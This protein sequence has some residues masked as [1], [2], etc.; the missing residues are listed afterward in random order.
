MFADLGDSKTGILL[1]ILMDL[2]TRSSDQLKGAGHVCT[3][4]LRAMI[5]PFLFQVSKEIH[6]SSTE[7]TST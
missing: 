3:A 4:E 5:P 1:M 2:Q 6:S 7:T